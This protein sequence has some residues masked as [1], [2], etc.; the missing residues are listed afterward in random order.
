MYD[1]KTE[2]KEKQMTLEQLRAAKQISNTN[3]R[4]A[5]HLTD[6]KWQKE[7]A[8]RKSFLQPYDKNI[9]NLNG[10]ESGTWNEESRGSYYGCTNWQSYC[11]YINDIL[12]NIHQGGTDY[13]F[14]IYQVMELAK[15][16][17]NDLKTKYRDGYWEV[18][19]EN[20]T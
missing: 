20:E 10:K 7:F 18:W 19:L 17:F 9:K 8:I 2:R 16:H 14:F 4:P 5:F 1:I 12:N 6:E 3:G 15:F 11:S 13:C